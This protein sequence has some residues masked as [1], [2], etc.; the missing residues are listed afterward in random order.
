MNIRAQVIKVSKKNTPARQLTAFKAGKCQLQ[1]IFGKRRGSRLMK[2][3]EKS[4][5]SRGKKQRAFKV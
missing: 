2:E 1:G 3:R 4:C 5:I